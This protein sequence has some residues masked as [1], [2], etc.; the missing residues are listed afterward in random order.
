MCN[1]ITFENVNHCI[2]CQIEKEIT[3]T[4]YIESSSL[5]FSKHK[6]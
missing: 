2:K 3:K 5:L 4:F 6:K 1:T